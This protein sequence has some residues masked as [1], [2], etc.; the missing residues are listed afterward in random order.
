MAQARPLLFGAVLLTLALPGHPL[1]PLSGLPLDLPA[2]VVVLLVVGWMIALPGAPPRSPLL[3]GL[4]V[5]L[6]LAKATV[7]WLAPAYGL[8]GS[9]RLDNPSMAAL[10]SW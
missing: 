9:Y 2:L 10:E 6:A 3:V 8:D 7:G 1:V 5:A 4:L